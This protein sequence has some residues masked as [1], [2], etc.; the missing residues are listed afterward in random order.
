VSRD[1]PI[2][3]ATQGIEL[4]MFRLVSCARICGKSVRTS[5]SGCLIGTLG[6]GF[7]NNNIILV[8]KL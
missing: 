4:V 5:G 1:G 7:G 8:P 2:R 6:D 3:Q